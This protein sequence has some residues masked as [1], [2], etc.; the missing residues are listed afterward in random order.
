LRYKLEYAWISFESGISSI[1]KKSQKYK[2]SCYVFSNTERFYNNINDFAK[3]TIV[4]DKIKR[5]L[6][7]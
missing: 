6:N 4:I 3:D 1:E 5:L 7:K 2:L